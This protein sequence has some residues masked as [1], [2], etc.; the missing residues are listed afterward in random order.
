[1]R[2]T[3]HSLTTRHWW[4]EL[5]RVEVSCGVH[6]YVTVVARSDPNPNA[7]AISFRLCLFIDNKATDVG[8]AF[9]I[10]SVLATSLD[11]LLVSCI[12]TSNTALDGGA[13][14]IISSGVRIMSCNFA[15]NRARSN[16][17]AI[18][19][20]GS[21][22]VLIDRAGEYDETLF[23]SNN[24]RIGGAIFVQGGTL[25]VL[26]TRVNGN[27]AVDEIYGGGGMFIDVGS[28]VSLSDT[29]LYENSA[30]N[31]GALYI[32]GG[33]VVVKASCH[34][35]FNRATRH[36]GAIYNRGSPIEI[37]SGTAVTEIYLDIISNSAGVLGGAVFYVTDGRSCPLFLSDGSISSH[38]FVTI[39][40]NSAQAGGGLYITAPVLN[41]MLVR[42][43]NN[44]ASA[45]GP[46]IA[47]DPKMLSA[48]FRNITCS[49][50]ALISFTIQLIDGNAQNVSGAF[51]TT[52]VTLLVAGGAVV[53]GQDIASVS[54]SA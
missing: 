53:I 34:L 27:A 40:G 7:R 29:G 14:G 11:F 3:A 41:C 32:A 2:S 48:S 50:S 5:L 43:T 26:H 52:P 23:T 6:R 19:L 15:K 30:H 25:N 42:I 39:A 49:P 17:G 4:E 44:R 13:L 10:S 37:I 18:S 8:G 54:S 47:T 9:H 28:F 51:V 31:G 38:T 20:F 33:F 1:M 21:S 22:V 35:F 12:F 24:A 36:G 46:S 45:Y 16:G